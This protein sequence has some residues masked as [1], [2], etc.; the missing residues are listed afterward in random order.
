MRIFV[1]GASGFV[2]SAIVAELLGAGH[3]VLGLVRSTAA[4]EVLAQAGGEAYLGN[5]ND[6]EGLKHA[7]ATCHAVIHTAFNHDFSRYKENCEH[8]R[9]VIQALGQALAGTGKPLL[10]TS[11]VGLLHYPRPVTENDAA[12]AAEVMPRGA[13]E[14]A[15]RAVAAQGVNVYVVRLP[16]SVH[17]VG[18]HGFVPILIDLAKEKGAAVYINGGQ[19][20][21]PAVHRL[22]AAVLYRLIVEQQPTLKVLHA[23][24]EEGIAFS[25]LAEAI[26]QGLQVP[27]VNREAA[28]AEAHFGWFAHFAGMDCTASSQLTRSALGWAPVQPGLLA[29]LA[30]GV[31][32]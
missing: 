4:A 31:Y 19:N 24:A 16:P 13:T 3:Q 23:V 5:L 12:P 15:A 2:G 9:W 22:D 21:W 7:A 20:R 29:D 17:G 30:S 25:Q 27:A 1:T 8:D 11:G 32:F 26:A 28:E 6:L 18:D 14:E 10:V